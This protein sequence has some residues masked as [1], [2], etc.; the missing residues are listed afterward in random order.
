MRDFHQC[1][2][3]PDKNDG[4][5]YAKATS[6]KIE[7]LLH[8]EIEEIKEIFPSSA[9]SYSLLE[10]RL[11]TNLTQTLQRLEDMEEHSLFKTMETRRAFYLYL[12]C[13]RR[14]KNG[15]CMELLIVLMP[16]QTLRVSWIIKAR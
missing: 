12:A 15:S 4:K 9:S 14:C 10:K 3:N 6:D 8:K 16:M 13:K 11:F 5:E 1:T 2:G 7:Q